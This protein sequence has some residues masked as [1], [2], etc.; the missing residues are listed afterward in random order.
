MKTIETNLSGKK[1]LYGIDML[2]SFRLDVTHTGGY[3]TTINN[4]KE[5][6]VP[7]THPLTFA[8]DLANFQ[9]AATTLDTVPY[10]YIEANT[11]VTYFLYFGYMG[12]VCLGMFCMMGF[13]G[14]ACSLWFNKVIFASIKID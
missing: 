2:T 13:V 3:F 12:L 8:L 6:I 9:G 5:R 7:G 11:M 1:P 14:V 10:G 4:V